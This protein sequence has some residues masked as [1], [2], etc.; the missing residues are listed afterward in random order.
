[1]V[2]APQHLGDPGDFLAAVPAMLGFVPKQSLVVA[3]LRPEPGRM[4]AAAVDVVVR[5]DF[6]GPGRTEIGQMVDRVAEICRR[7]HAGAALALIV[8]DLGTTATARHRGERARRHRD[9]IEA[10]AARLAAEEVPLA[11]AWATAEIAP[12]RPWWSVLGPERT[13]VQPDPAASLVTLGHVLEGRPIRASRAELTAVVAVD[14]AERAAVDRVLADVVAD[15]R[16]RLARAARRRDPQSFCRAA[17]LRVLSQIAQVESGADLEPVEL[18]ELAVALRDST[19]RDVMYALS[20][21][22]HAQAAE[23]LWVRLTRCLPDPDRAEAAALLAYS[24]YVRGDGTLA[25]VALHAALGSDPGHTMA[26]LLDAALQSGM[27]P[28]EL[29]RLAKSGREAAKDLGVDL[30]M[31]GA[32]AD[33]ETRR[34]GDRPR[35]ADREND[36]GA[37]ER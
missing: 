16:Q 2:V 28:E 9:L 8:D 14:R 30:G 31:M 20:P 7:Q 1:M 10:L 36:S 27:R 29:R 13:G 15:A 37:G 12:D 23:T 35:L 19:V 22:D 4:D 3:V 24:A 25:G 26:R 5:L 32:G 11:G 6:H 18:A 17:L 33:V 21:G 34:R